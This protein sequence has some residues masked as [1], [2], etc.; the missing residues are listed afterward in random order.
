MKF[1]KDWRRTEKQMT[2]T[3]V[4]EQVLVLRDSLER[5]GVGNLSNVLSIQVSGQ[6]SNTVNIEAVAGDM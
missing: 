6:H 1:F 5:H 3:F 4:V 2:L